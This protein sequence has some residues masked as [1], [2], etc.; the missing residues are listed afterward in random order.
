MIGTC[1][2]CGKSIENGDPYVEGKDCFICPDCI[3]RI[4]HMWAQMAGI[5]LPS[6]NTT[7]ETNIEQSLKKPKEIKEYLDRFIIGQDEYKKKISIAIYNHY[8]RLIWSKKNND[9]VIKKDSVLVLGN[10]GTGKTYVVQKISEMLDIPFAICDA[11]TLTEAGYVGDDVESV[12][13]KLYQNAGQSVERTEHGIIFIDEIDKIARKGDNPSITRDVS[14]EGVQQG[15][16]KMIEG[17]VIGIPPHGG[18]KH[19]DQDLVYIDTKN[20]LF[21]CAGAFEGI[22]RTIGRRLNQ[23]TIGYNQ[24]L[25]HKY[26]DDELLDNVTPQDLR[27][28]GLIPEIIGRLPVIC[29]TNSLSVDD[30]VKILNEPEDSLVKQYQNLM[31]M[32]ECKLSFTDDALTEIANNA[33][34]SGT[35][36]RGLRH[37]MDIIM[38]DYMYEIPS[39]NEKEVI[40][41]LD[42]VKEKLQYGKRK[43]TSNN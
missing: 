26:N 43:D 25:K 9:G 8:K 38:T 3:Q 5:S 22:E 13:V 14:G 2:V 29:H 19:P 24:Q 17:N 28:F 4:G 21:I 39:T 18:R 10:S 37:I 33:I 34:K 1:N 30:M 20:I 32:D 35:G 11:T 15:L 23:Y 12:L 31:I 40:I 6:V 36:A 16:L 7:D 42:L 27:S 41:T